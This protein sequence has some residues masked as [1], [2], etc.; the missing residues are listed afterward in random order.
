MPFA[1]NNLP[2][3]FFPRR[4]NRTVVKQPGILLDGTG[5]ATALLNQDVVSAGKNRTG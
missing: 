1:L 3:Q 5:A 2:N 4:N